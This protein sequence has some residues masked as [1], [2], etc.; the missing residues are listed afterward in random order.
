M[1]LC[2][3]SDLLQFLGAPEKRHQTILGSSAL[4]WAF[5]ETKG[6]PDNPGKGHAVIG[7]VKTWVL[8]FS[9]QG[10]NSPLQVKTD[11]VIESVMSEGIG[12]LNID[13]WVT[14]SSV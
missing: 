5:H 2:K 9:A 13:C 4:Q 7:L 14:G 1:F 10:N 11:S 12:V 6:I 8:T 3:V